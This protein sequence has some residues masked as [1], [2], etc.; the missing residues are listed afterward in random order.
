MTQPKPNRDDWKDSGG[1]WFPP[2]TVPTSDLN[3]YKT[4][5]QTP[6]GWAMLKAAVNGGSGLATM[7]YKLDTAA[8]VG[9]PP[10]A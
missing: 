6:G 9:V 5:A 1:G 3:D 2:S 7:E 10:E 8:P 4:W